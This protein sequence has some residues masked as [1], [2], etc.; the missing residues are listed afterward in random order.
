MNRKEMEKYFKLLEQI[1]SE[2]IDIVKLY[3]L[4]YVKFTQD[5]E[6]EE[7]KIVEYCYDMWLKI[8][9]DIDLAKLADI[10]V[11]NWE[12]I[13]ENKYGYNNIINDIFV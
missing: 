4:N 10:V 5:N 6:K 12:D 3:L 9:A 7:W 11:E 1:E 2:K 13:K 8:D